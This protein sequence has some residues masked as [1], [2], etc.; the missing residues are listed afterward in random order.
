MLARVMHTFADFIAPFDPVAF[1]R[2]YFGKKPCHIRRGTAAFDNPL[3]WQRFN[4]VLGLPTYWNE[5]T[6]KVYYRSRS[7]LR[8]NYCDVSDLAPG[9]KA[10]ADPRKVKV[11][12]G[13]G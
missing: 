2:D 11:L 13:L 8:E 7:A 6:L 5:D 10:P 9:A 4:D 12:L 3:P 1:K